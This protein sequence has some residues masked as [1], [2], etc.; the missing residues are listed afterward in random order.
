MNTM[1]PGLPFT[2]ASGAAVDTTKTDMPLVAEK[3][4]SKAPTIDE[5][6]WYS[7]QDSIV[8]QEQ[9]AVAIYRNQENELIIRQERG[10]DE[11]D[12]F[13]VITKDN[14]QAFLDALCDALGV[15]SAP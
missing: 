11:E 6:D 5:F 3:P 1:P 2:V 12:D 8:L 4:I 9:R 13:I 15:G 14:E 10:H 7:G